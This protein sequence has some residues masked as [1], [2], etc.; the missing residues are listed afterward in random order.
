MSFRIEIEKDECM[1][2]GKCV[3]DYPQMFNFDNEELAELKKDGKLNNEQI[4]KAARNCPSRA[5]LVFDQDNNQI[6]S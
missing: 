5:I 2:S 1:S 3:A 6:S 4:L